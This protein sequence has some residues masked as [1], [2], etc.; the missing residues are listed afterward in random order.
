[1]GHSAS[2]R[3]QVIDTMIGLTRLSSLHRAIV[4]GHDSMELY[5]A[6]RRRGF[7]RVATTATCRIPKQ[8]HAVGLITGQNSLA[9]IEAALAQISQFLSRSAA[10]AVLID[11]RESGVCLKVR[12]RLEQMGFRIEA[13]VRCQQGLVLSAY[14]QGFTQ[15]EIAA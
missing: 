6:L 3:E 11:S 2:N 15:M 14:R 12:T 10:I 9:A 8:Q 5:L 7:V 1:M 4:A 13:G